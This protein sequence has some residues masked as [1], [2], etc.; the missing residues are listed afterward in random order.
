LKIRNTFEPIT[1]YKFCPL[2]FRTC[3]VSFFTFE[4]FVQSSHNILR[5]KG[6][7]TK[8]LC[9]LGPKFFRTISR[10]NRCLTLFKS[11]R[12]ECRT[13]FV[14]IRQSNKT[15]DLTVKFLNSIKLGSFLRKFSIQQKLETFKFKKDPKT[16]NEI[17]FLCKRKRFFKQS[18]ESCNFAGILSS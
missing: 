8:H 12:T 7:K 18:T 6:P 16:R 4:N 14:A 3:S 5:S 1:R 15:P 11:R 13:K 2:F 17:D 9:L 10:L